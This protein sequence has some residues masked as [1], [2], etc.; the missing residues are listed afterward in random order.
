MNGLRL[1]FLV[2]SLQCMT[3][4]GGDLVKIDGDAFHELIHACEK[5]ER[6]LVEAYLVC[7]HEAKPGWMQGGNKPKTRLKATVVG[8]IR[9][10]RCVGEWI[11]FERTYEAKAPRDEAYYL[12]KLYYVFLRAFTD[13]HAY[14]V[15]YI[16]VDP[17]D[18]EVM[19]GYS[20]ERAQ[21]AAAHVAARK[22]VAARDALDFSVLDNVTSGRKVTPEGA[23]GFVQWGKD[24]RGRVCYL[25]VTSGLDQAALVTTSISKINGG[26]GAVRVEGEIKVPDRLISLPDRN[27]NFLVVSK[28]AVRKDGFQPFP[29][30]WLK[31]Y[32]VAAQAI[33]MSTLEEFLKSKDKE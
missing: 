16:D 24:R 10:G 4:H 22:K 21:T 31:E 7:I 29:E 32:L 27:A 15:R 30:E 12:G 5:G 8:V 9:G 18:P 19:F 20:V 23:L 13:R 25:V 14:R 1:L 26:V 33:D 6:G 3:A 2:M 28:D 11:E 17:Q